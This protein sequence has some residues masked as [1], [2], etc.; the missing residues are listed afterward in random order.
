MY[1]DPNWSPPDLSK[2]YEAVPSFVMVDGKVFLHRVASYAE[3]F[4]TFS[5]QYTGEHKCLTLQ[6]IRDIWV[7]MYEESGVDKTRILHSRH[8]G[9]ECS[10]KG[11][12]RFSA[13]TARSIG[14]PLGRTIEVVYQC[15]I[16][17]Y[18]LNGRDWRIGKGKPSVNGKSYEQLYEDYYAEWEK[19]GNAHLPWM[20]E[21]HWLAT[22]NDHVLCDRFASGRINQARALA[23]WCTNNNW[24]GHSEIF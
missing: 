2:H 10:S 24:D 4:Y 20:R 7:K 23:D 19:W 8:S 21:L 1:N 16:K 3:G 22:V 5:D 17:G 9:Y 11:D 15:V 6:Q 18:D 14:D 13:F 12:A